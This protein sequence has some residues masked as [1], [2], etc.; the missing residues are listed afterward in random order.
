MIESHEAAEVLLMKTPHA[1]AH[2]GQI[3]K[4]QLQLQKGDISPSAQDASEINKV[5]AYGSFALTST[6]EKGI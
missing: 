1:H 2:R 3:N 4:V 5:S 6:L